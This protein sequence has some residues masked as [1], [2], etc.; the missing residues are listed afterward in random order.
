MMLNQQVNSGKYTAIHGSYGN[1]M[2][3]FS[4]AIFVDLGMQIQILLQAQ[5]LKGLNH[6]KYYVLPQ[7]KKKSPQK[8]P[9]QKE[10]IIIVQPSFRTYKTPTLKEPWFLQYHQKK[11]SVAQVLPVFFW[12]LSPDAHSFAEICGTHRQDHEFLWVG[13]PSK[14]HGFPSCLRVLTHLFRPE[15]KKTSTFPWVGWGPKE[16]IFLQGKSGELEPKMA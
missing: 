8:R 16:S 10:L 9:L 14:P 4:N 12:H 13:K 1:R 15:K 6:C 7:S 3:S 2:D 5:A 11:T